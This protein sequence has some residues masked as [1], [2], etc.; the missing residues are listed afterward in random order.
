VN[1]QVKPR[2][3]E[4]EQSAEQKE[5]LAAYDKLRQRVKQILGET[6]EA[7]NADTIKHVLDRAGEE[8]KEIGGHPREVIAKATATLQKDLASTAEVVK[9]RLEELGKGTEQAFKLFRERGG[10]FWH[11]LSEDTGHI[12]EIWRDK[13]GG[14]LA[15]VAKGVG[16]WSQKMGDNL[17][18][19]L[20]YH[21]GE[22]THGGTFNCTACGTAVEL[23][24]PGHLPSC[25]ECHKSEFRRA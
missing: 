17:N 1:D 18:E 23:K 2:E 14:F 8:L 7:I 12:F 21:T 3:T 15:V 4:P 11:E 10:A 13:G 6:K 9:P 25:P 16:E 19:V 22:A 20:L 5:E 24:K